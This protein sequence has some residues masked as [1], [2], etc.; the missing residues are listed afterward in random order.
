[1]KTAVAFALSAVAAQALASPMSLRAGETAIFNFDFVAQGVSPAPTYSSGVILVP[2]V[3]GCCTGDSL[4]WS[5]HGGLDASGFVAYQAATALPSS[6][7]MFDPT[8][9]DGLF[10]LLVEVV[11]GEISI[12]PY[13][14]GVAGGAHNWQR[15]PQVQG[16]A[17][18]EGPALQ[19]PAPA[20][21]VL[22]GLGLCLA[23]AARV[24]RTA[25][26]R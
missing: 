18:G 1:M 25:R 20:S 15:T 17:S 10:S 3:V 14:V 4:V 8:V 16:V 9:L 19:V 7:L 2:G 23:A 11:A 21:G 5:V 13:A 24:R 22:A 26:H 6:K 12:D